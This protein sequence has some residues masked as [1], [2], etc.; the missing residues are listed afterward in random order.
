MKRFI[1]LSLFTIYSAIFPIIGNAHFIK[2]NLITSQHI[3]IADPLSK[4]DRTFFTALAHRE[5]DNNPRK[6]NKFGYIGKYQ[7]GEEALVALGYYYKDDT[8]KNDWKGQWTGKDG[9]FS[10]EDFLN[11]SF[12]QDKAAKELS[13]SNWDVAT[14]NNLDSYIGKRINGALITKAGIVAGMH[15][16]GA[17][18]VIDFIKS[19]QDSQ[20]AFGTSVHTYMKKFSVYQ[21]S[22]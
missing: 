7:F 2:A 8:K 14:R 22:L 18:S 5:S 6:I 16:K 3:S 15:L 11:N 10:K 1:I 9:V 12:I 17:Q 13:S 19:S 4:K 20:D 21:V